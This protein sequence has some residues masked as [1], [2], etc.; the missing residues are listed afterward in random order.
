MVWVTVRARIR[1]RAR[2]RVRI[3]TSATDE[4]FT[5]MCNEI[6]AVEVYM[7]ITLLWLRLGLG[8]GQWLV[9]ES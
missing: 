4:V 8:L 5:S 3:T 6:T 2:V 7:G 9:L 1:V